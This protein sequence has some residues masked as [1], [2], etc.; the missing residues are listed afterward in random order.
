MSDNTLNK[1]LQILG[2]GTGPRR[3]PLRARPLDCVDLLDDQ[4]GAFDGD[5]VEVQ[6]AHD[7]E[8]KRRRPDEVVGR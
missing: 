1:P 2:C 8:K 5:V 6:L 7:T 4:Q 3:R